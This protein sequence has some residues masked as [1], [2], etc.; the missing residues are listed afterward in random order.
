MSGRD[1]FGRLQISQTRAPD[2]RRGVEG[3]LRV[4]AEAEVGIC[5]STTPAPMTQ[6]RRR[7][8][9]EIVEAT[10]TPTVLR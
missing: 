9:S 4:R 10:A 5:A 7:Q 3:A 2:V 8:T 1:L 6:G